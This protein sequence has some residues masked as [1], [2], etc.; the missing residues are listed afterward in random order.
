MQGGQEPVQPARELSRPSEWRDEP[1]ACKVAD[2]FPDPH[3]VLPLL[4]VPRLRA[5]GTM[6][7]RVYVGFTDPSVPESEV[8][9]SLGGR[10]ARAI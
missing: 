1:R 10:D 6:G 4:A 7:T 8:I 5:H 9:P 3:N 2:L